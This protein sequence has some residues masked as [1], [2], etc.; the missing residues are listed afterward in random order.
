VKGAVTLRTRSPGCRVD[1]KENAARGRRKINQFFRER[2]TR[3]KPGKKEQRKRRERRSIGFFSRRRH[4]G[5][6]L[7]EKKA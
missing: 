3:K 4:N 2:K 5:K 7:S 6:S 1:I